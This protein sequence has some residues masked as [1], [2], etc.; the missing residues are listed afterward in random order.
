M[1]SKKFPAFQKMVDD[2]IN[3]NSN[4]YWSPL[5]MFA[6]MVEEVGEIARIIN[7][8]ED[9]KPLKS[10]KNNTNELNLKE[11]L[12]DVFFALTCIANNYKINLEFTLLDSI[13][14]F[15]IRDSNRIT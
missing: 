9:S 11:E 14:K 15:K 8:L 6:A 7:A 12:G 13:N 5:A 1:D 2:Y 4:G 10:I 3:N